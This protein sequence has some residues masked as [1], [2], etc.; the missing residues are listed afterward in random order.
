MLTRHERWIDR[1]YGHGEGSITDSHRG[2]LNFGLWDPGIEDYA[3]AAENLVAALGARLGLGPGAR[4]VDVACGRGV[5]DFF[6]LRRFGALSIDAVDVTLRNVTTARAQ[7]ARH[8]GPGEVHF[9]HGSATR[10]PFADASFS[11]ALSVEAAFHF[12]TREAFVGEAWRVLEPGG[13]LALADIVQARPART[14]RERAIVEAAC[15]LWRIPAA[16]MGELSG[17]RTMLARQGF[18]VE[19]IDHVGPRTF[20]GYYRAQRAPARRRELIAARGRVGA[21]VGAL[22]NYAAH[23]V[24]ASGL[25]DYL[26]VSAVK[27]GR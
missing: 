13:R 23:R 10:L 3:A 2:Y 6:L 17:Y 21:T 12:D 14:R 24:F 16:N 19:S 20:P 9:H 1:M 7:A 11:H 25:L 5:Q 26:L 27:E 8:D 18:V 22:L 4:L 15:R